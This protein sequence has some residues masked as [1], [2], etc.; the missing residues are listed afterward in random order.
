VEAASKKRRAS[1]TESGGGNGN[2]GGGGGGAVAEESH[3]QT[4]GPASGGGGG[5][6]GG[7]AAKAAAKQQ[8]QLQQQKQQQQQQQKREAEAA[9][10][11]ALAAAEP[12][13]VYAS[14]E[15]A[16]EAFRAV[17]EEHGIP[18]SM[19]YK[20]V[21]EICLADKRWNALKTVGDKKQNLAEYQTKQA[22]AEKEEHRERTR[23]GR[24]AFLLM[25]AEN[26]QIDHN[27]RWRTAQPL[28]VTD[29]RYKAVEDEGDREDIFREFVQELDKKEREDAARAR[30]EAVE[31]FKQ[32]LGDLYE[33]GKITR[34]SILWAEAKP[35]L[36]DAIADVRYASM[37]EIEM[38]HCLQ[39]FT[40]ELIKKHKEDIKAKRVVQRQVCEDKEVL[41]R[42][43]LKKLT[44]DNSASAAAAVADIAAAADIAAVAA[45]AADV[46]AVAAAADAAD[47]AAKAIATAIATAPI[48][49]YLTEYKTVKDRLEATEEYTELTDSYVAM[50]VLDAALDKADGRGTSPSRG[51]GSSG[52]A[53]S[54][55][56]TAKGLF[57]AFVAELVIEYR[58]DKKL[59]KNTLVDAEVKIAY[60]SDPGELLQALRDVDASLTA[61]A[62][63]PE[64]SPLHELL[65]M[66]EYMVRKYF[67]DEIAILLEDREDEL[68]AARKLETRFVDLLEDYYYRSDHVD[69]SWEDAKE[70]L[71][72]YATHT[73]TTTTTTIAAIAAIATI[74]TN[75]VTT[76]LLSLFNSSIDYILTN[77]LILLMHTHLS[78][79]PLPP[80][81]PPLPPLQEDCL[82]QPR[83]GG[84][85]ADIRRLHGIP[86]RQ[87]RGQEAPPR[88]RGKWKC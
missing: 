73:T 54:K 37:T 1:V 34:K 53:R 49:S 55:T 26:T 42:A 76:V 14:R 23:K 45:A 81:P 82:L 28:L 65:E 21:Q 35:A 29:A 6:G 83:A 10:A 4:A 11:A 24:A 88:R 12:E 63:E 72:K 38:R 60:N 46:D 33:E 32:H 74:I 44:V 16:T 79:L 77:L 8:Q 78:Y 43:M 19:K 25:L 20:E 17:L 61:A 39:H 2:G 69:V 64:D 57:D 52:S 58:G 50:S 84:A 5:G 47:A 7:A 67:A 18:S 51:R 68:K 85:A 71:Y 31:S 9:A 75:V 48:I 30:K 80:P 13:I 62:I 70:D 87:A 59:V 27:A 56:K 40:A 3:A 15:E 36:A 86:R 66:R 22:K 41:F